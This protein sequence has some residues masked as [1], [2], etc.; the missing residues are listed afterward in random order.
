M[1]PELEAELLKHDMIEKKED[2]QTIGALTFRGMACITREILRTKLFFTLVEVELF[3]SLRDIC[4]EKINIEKRRQQQTRGNHQTI[5]GASPTKA[6]EP[7]HL[8]VGQELRKE[9]IVTEIREETVVHSKYILSKC[10]SEEVINRISADLGI[11]CLLGRRYFDPQYYNISAEVI[12]GIGLII[13]NNKF[14][15]HGVE[16]EGKT[17][18]SLFFKMG[19]EITTMLNK[20]REAIISKANEIAENDISALGYSFLAVGIC[21]QSK[22]N[23][24][25]A[26]DGTYSFH[27]DLKPIFE[28]KNCP[29]LEGKPKIF[30]IHSCNPVNEVFDDGFGDITMSS[31]SDECD[32]MVVHS[33]VMRGK[34]FTSFDC[35]FIANLEKTFDDHRDKDHLRSI[36]GIAD[37][38][39]KPVESEGVGSKEYEQKCQRN[40]TLT[41]LI[42]IPK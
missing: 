37:S 19:L 20:T 5:A 28:R 41:K 35:C 22:D 33:T 21:T 38:K 24:L 17:L 27:R 2:F 14:E 15:G 42:F 1:D 25:S 8:Q 40:S 6:G 29:G 11:P 13:L 39:C 34:G 23:K 36:I 12:K 32:I 7:A 4:I 30:F 3:E 10:P 16:V 18:R 9:K 31:N 26:S